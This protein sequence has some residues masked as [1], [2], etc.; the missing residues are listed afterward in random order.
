MPSWG[1]SPGTSSPALASSCA[2]PGCGR[3]SA[4]APSAPTTTR[5]AAR[6][7]LRP[8]VR[9]RRRGG[10]H[11]PAPARGAGGLSAGPLVRRLL[12]RRSCRPVP[13]RILT[14]AVLWLHVLGVVVWLGGVMYQAHVLLP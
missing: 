1:S 5:A 4:W 3:T 10:G 13:V 9:S 12:G 7:R 14:L 2:R 8:R 11:G 6:R